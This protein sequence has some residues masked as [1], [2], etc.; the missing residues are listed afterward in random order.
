MSKWM[1]E[2]STE[3]VA[4]HD[5]KLAERRCRRPANTI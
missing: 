1:Q 5:L 4:P 2:W 3:T